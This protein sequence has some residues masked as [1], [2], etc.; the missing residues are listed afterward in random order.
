MPEMGKGSRRRTDK[1]RCARPQGATSPN[2]LLDLY[3]PPDTLLWHSPLIKKPQR[4]L[5]SFLHFSQMPFLGTSLVVQW[6]RL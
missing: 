3:I 2:K 4:C 6:L 1:E 5:L